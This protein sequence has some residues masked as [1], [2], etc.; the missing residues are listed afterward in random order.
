M[1]KK[2]QL[3]YYISLIFFPILFYFGKRSPVTYDEGYYI[4]QAKWIL[5]NK[6]WISP[7]YWQELALDRTNSIQSLIAFSQKTFGNNSFS[8][9][10]P[11][12]LV[13]S[14]MLF[15]TYQIHKE[16]IEKKYAIFSS[17]ILSTTFLWVNYFHMASQDII[18]G[19]LIT[20]GLFAT[21]KGYKNNKNL[22]FLLS[23]IWIGLAVFFKT[24]LT[25]IPLLAI[26]PFLKSSKIL[27]KKYFWIGTFLGFLPFLIWSNN[28][29]SLYGFEAYSGLYKKLLV[30]SKENNF[31]NPVYFYL[32]NLVLNSFPWSIFSIIGFLNNFDMQ[33][34]VSKYFLLYYPAIVILFLSIFSTKT[35]YYPIQILSI[36]SINTYLGI[37]Y[38]FKRQNIFV[39]F[40]KN[41]FFRVLPVILILSIPYVHIKGYISEFNLI[42]K[43]LIN[44]SLFIFAISWLIL[45]SIKNIKNKLILIIIG[46]YLIFSTAVQSGLLSDRSKD[47]RIESEAIIKR[48]SLQKKKIEF[49]VGDPIDEEANNKLIKIAIFMPKIGN[50]IKNIKSMKTGQYAWTVQSNEDIKN[51]KNFKIIANPEILSP[52]KLIVKE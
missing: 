10:I 19:T 35:P 11:N 31:T 6:D 22:Y 46:P 39:F 47:L 2:E 41:L 34:K 36:I 18:F 21:I 44:F 29:I 13:G 16:L 20:L 9:Y 28:I 7:Q 50:G 49:I 23:G 14:I 38:I 3:K 27:F 1:N 43:I 40:L 45:P 17:L 25:V 42:F 51:K 37:I 33:D 32:W 5:E 30:L 15:L 48:E 12:I 8:I 24:Y 4:L 26:L 52:W